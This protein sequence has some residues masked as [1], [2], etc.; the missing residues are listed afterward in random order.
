MKRNILFI[1]TLALILVALE[2]CKHE[3]KTTIVKTTTTEAD[4]AYI[5]TKYVIGSNA[6]TFEFPGITNPY[7]DSLTVEG[8]Q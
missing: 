1:F 4:S 3:P 8:I 7:K 2:N 6:L 5:G